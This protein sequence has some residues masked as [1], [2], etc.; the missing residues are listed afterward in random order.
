MACWWMIFCVWPKIFFVF[1]FNCIRANCNR[2]A[3]ALATEALSSLSEQ[4]WL[5]DFPA[6]ILPIVQ[7]D[8]Q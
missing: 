7:S 5:E 2:A 1:S 8:Y 6:V 3:Q 4:V